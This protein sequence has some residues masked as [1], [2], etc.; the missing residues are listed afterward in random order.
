MIRST[1]RTCSACHHRHVSTLALAAEPEPLVNGSTLQRPRPHRL[2]PR[3]PTSNLRKLRRHLPRRGWH[4]PRLLRQIRRRLWRGAASSHLF[5]RAI[6]E[7]YILRV[8]TGSSGAVPRQPP[9]GFMN[10]GMM[11]H[12][13]TPDLMGLDQRF[14]VCVEFQLLGSLIHPRSA[15]RKRLHTRHRHRFQRQTLPPRTAEQHQQALPSRPMGHRRS[16]S[17]RRQSS[18][19]TKSTARP[20]SNT[21]TSRSTPRCGRQKLIEA[22]ARPPPDLRHHL[23]P[24]RKSPGRIPQS[25]AVEALGIGWLT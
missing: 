16:G 3:S 1:C 11:L 9:R 20:S 14:P 18:S 24:V 17:P 13:Q 7:S 19:A 6:L 8:S 15:D 12:G 21:T 2:D 10:S 5:Y 23:A 22:G 4:P 25:R